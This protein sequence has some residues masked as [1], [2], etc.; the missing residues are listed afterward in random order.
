MGACAHRRP[1]ACAGAYAELLNQQPNEVSSLTLSKQ[2]AWSSPLAGFQQRLDPRSVGSDE[3]AGGG[4]HELRGAVDIAGWSPEVAVFHPASCGLCANEPPAEARVDD[5]GRAQCLE[6]RFGSRAGSVCSPQTRPCPL[7][8]GPAAP[9]QLASECGRAPRALARGHRNL[10]QPPAPGA[11]PSGCGV[12]SR[13]RRIHQH[14][15]LAEDLGEERRLAVCLFEPHE[16]DV[17]A[18]RD[19]QLRREVNDPVKA[20]VP[21]AL[22]R[23]LR[24]GDTKVFRSD[25]GLDLGQ[26]A[27]E[28]AGVDPASRAA[29]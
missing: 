26:C 6:C 25:C 23:R 29:A 7:C 1:G 9:M 19:V 3:V 20:R 16:V 12:C 5:L 15:T 17:A 14:A 24:G 22:P 28:I 27:G 10:A 18:S 8:V 4:V 2:R 11:L 13:L 21:R